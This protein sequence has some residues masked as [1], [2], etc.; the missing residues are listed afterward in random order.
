MA[1][2]LQFREKYDISVNACLTPAKKLARH[3]WRVKKGSQQQGQKVG[4][5]H[6]QLFFLVWD[7]L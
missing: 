7:G 4:I 1:G 2:T 6:A 5:M 3:I